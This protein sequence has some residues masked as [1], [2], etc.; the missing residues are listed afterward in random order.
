MHGMIAGEQQQQQDFEGDWF[1]VRCLRRTD[2]EAIETLKRYHVPTYYPKIVELR[3]MPLRRLS[4]SQRT[5]SIKI[6]RPVQAPMF[7]R[8]VLIQMDGILINWRIVFEEA[9]IA[10]FACSEGKVGRL[11][12]GELVRMRSQENGGLI[13]GRKSLKVVFGIGDEV[14][15]T[16]GPFAAF[17]AIIE[18]GLDVAIGDLDPTT[19]IKVAVNL[20]GR[21]TPVELE[22]WQ[23]SK[24]D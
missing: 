6:Q 21:P 23:V 19:R 20:F 16:S 10:G 5:A 12:H 3:P 8:Y 2:V 17:P 11:R 7:P 1:M 9:G 22:I 24:R 13:E 14:T 4:A 18:R 15:V